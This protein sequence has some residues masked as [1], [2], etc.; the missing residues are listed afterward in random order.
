[1][2]RSRD[3]SSSQIAR[4]SAARPTRPNAGPYP[5]PRRIYSAHALRTRPVITAPFGCMGDSIGRGGSFRTCARLGRLR[6]TLPA[7]QVQ[8]IT[9]EGR[10]Y[11]GW[12]EIRRGL[13]ANTGTPKSSHKRAGPSLAFVEV[14][15]VL[16]LRAAKVKDVLPEGRLFSRRF[17]G[18]RAF[19]SG[20]FWRSRCAWRELS[21]DGLC[22]LT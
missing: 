5:R 13:R 2:W 10:V 19:R 12:V 21:T 3:P 6:T 17:R 8:S 11:T 15:M 4:P 16:Q 9:R 7:R 22:Q 14:Y 1:M 20:P 18:R